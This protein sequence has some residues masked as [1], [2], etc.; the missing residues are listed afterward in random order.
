MLKI[1]APFKSKEDVIPLIEA[2]ADELYCGYI[3]SEISKEYAHLPVFER[4]GG[5]TCNFTDIKELK[6]AVTLA[7]SRNTP[8]FCAFNGMYVK[9]QYTLLRKMIRHLEQTDL[10]AYI[11]ADMGLLLTLKGMKTKKEIFVSSFVPLFNFEAVAFYRNFGVSRVIL[12]RQV[13]FETMQVLCADFPDLDF[14]AFVLHLLCVNI[15]GFCTFAHIGAT[16][17]TPFSA[18]QGN[19]SQADQCQLFTTFDYRS[20]GDACCLRYSVEAIGASSGEP[21]HNGEVSPTFFKHLVDGVECGACAMYDFMKTGIKSVKIVGRQMVVEENIKSTKFIKAA[22]DI[23]EKN[24][25]I[26]RQDYIEQVQ[27]LYRETYGYKKP[28]RGNNCYHPEVL[29]K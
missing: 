6:N 25:Q 27:T 1:T 29:I 11:V 4:K 23:L 26:N 3:L 28:C 12:D 18:A 8:V 20:P 24:K 16:A 13:S 14:E 9:A 15:D 21:V 7:H 2:G 5:S 22:A 19:R 17:R 10:D